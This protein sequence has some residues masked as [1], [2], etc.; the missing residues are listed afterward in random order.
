MFDNKEFESFSNKFDKSVDILRRLCSIL[1][2]DDKQIHKSCEFQ[3]GPDVD[4]K[5]SRGKFKLFYD[6]HLTM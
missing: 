2:F 5:P 1:K 6:R 4:N 3:C